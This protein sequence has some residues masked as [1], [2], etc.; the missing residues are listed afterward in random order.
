MDPYFE[1]LPTYRIVVCLQCS[2]GVWPAAVSS[3]LRSEAHELTLH[4]ARGVA[5]DIADRHLDAVV[6]LDWIVI[7]WI[8]FGWILDGLDRRP[9]IQLDPIAPR[10]RS[11]T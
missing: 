5:Q 10:G 1:Y 11:I 6:L 8:G 2:V 3:H 9:K 7:G 4:Q